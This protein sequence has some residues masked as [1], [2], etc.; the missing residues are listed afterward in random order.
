MTPKRS[1]LIPLMLLL[2]P[3][4][5][6]SL[7]TPLLGQSPSTRTQQADTTSRNKTKPAGRKKKGRNTPTTR[8]DSLRAD[9]LRSL[10][11]HSDSLRTDSLRADSLRT[12]AM[13]ADSLGGLHTDSLGTDSVGVTAGSSGIDTVVTYSASHRM[14]FDVK[15]RQMHLYSD[16]SLVKGPQKLTAN[17]IRVDFNNSELFA[18]ARFDSATKTYSE[19]PVFHDGTQELSANSLTYNFRN[20]RGT[21]GAAETKMGDGFYYGARIK[22]VA[23]NTYF[24]QDGRYTTCEAPHPHFYFASPRMKVIANDRIFA[25]Q[26]A[27]YV[28]DV[29]IFYIPF[30]VYFSSQ[31][32]RQSGLII[33]SFDQ[34]PQRGL[35][36]VGLGLFFDLGSYFDTRFMADLYSKGGF[37][38]HNTTRFRLRGVIDAADLETSFGRTRF[39][40][41]SNFTTNYTLTYTHQMEIGRRGRLGGT[42]NFASENA[43]RNTY[44]VVQSGLS[45]AQQQNNYTTAT[46]GSNFS[47]NTSWSNGMSVSAD[48]RRDQNILNRNETTSLPLQFSVPSWTPFATPTGESIMDKLNFSVGGSARFN[49]EWIKQDTLPGGGFRTNDRR[50]GFSYVPTVSLS[51]KLGYFTIQPGISMSGSIFTRRIVKQA[52]GDTVIATFLPGIYPT[53][54]YGFGVSASTSLYGI[55]QPRLFGVN[56]IRHTFSPIISLNYVPDF[57]QAKYGYYDEVFN[58]RTNAIEKYSLFERDGNVGIIPGN[59]LQ[60]SIG[61]T[62]RNDFEAKVAQGDTLPDR[63]VRLLSLTLSTS[64]NAAAATSFRWSTVNAGATTDLGP[65]GNVSGNATFSLYDRDS[66]GNLIPELLIDKGKGLMR[67]ESAGITFGTSFTDQG[68]ATGVT[69]TIAGDSAAARRERFNFEHIPFNEPEFFGEDVT[70]NDQFRIPW[71]VSFTGNYNLSR[72]S[73]TFTPSLTLNT[74]FSF[75]LTPTLHIT[76]SAEYNVLAGAFLVP[77]INISKDL[78]C[79]LMTLDLVPAGPGRGFS[80]HLAPK[81][82]QL[83]DIIPPIRRIYY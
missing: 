47:Y 17:Y 83:R 54:T 12:A 39:D 10:Q 6:A 37:T 64:Y 46:L 74:T 61:L 72:L 81:A 19:V 52:V 21:L 27:L 76:S 45:Q 11:A 7:A 5:A 29:P 78:D 14:L 15:K 16:A 3:L 70:G 2:L 42:I 31:N 51:P 25:D 23:E 35:Q 30:G 67:M 18:L 80:F 55:V 71:Q 65:L 77:S 69:Q 62:L 4:L 49:I 8:N 48:F 75:A 82:P 63:K 41:D 34:T 28:A 79:W 38:L 50:Y 1:L 68:F 53:F 59:G 58:P 26:A 22:Q 36:L 13:H 56:A 20:K 44:S 60:Q 33:P 57:G 40:P 43:I 9:S 32:G 66:L 73:N 24:V